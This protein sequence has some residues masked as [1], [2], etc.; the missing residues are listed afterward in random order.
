MLAAATVAVATFVV[1]ALL[2]EWLV[3]AGLAVL[4]VLYGAQ[5]WYDGKPWWPGGPR[6]GA[7]GR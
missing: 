5:A 6:R 4:T 2:G 3:L 7:G 1:L